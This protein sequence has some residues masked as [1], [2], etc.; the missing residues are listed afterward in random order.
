MN[1][2][3]IF[4]VLFVFFLATVDKLAWFSVDAKLIG[5]IGV[6]YVVVRI[7]EAFHPFTI[8]WPTRARA[9]DE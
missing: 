5:Y 9:G 8:P 7:I 6:G 2:S 4:L 1:L 3:T